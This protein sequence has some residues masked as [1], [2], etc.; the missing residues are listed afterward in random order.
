MRLLQLGVNDRLTFT[1]YLFPHEIS[2]YE[3]A[4]LSHTWGPD[5]EE[6]T[7][8]DVTE[9]TGLKKKGYQKILFCGRQAAADNLGYFWVDTCCIDKPNLTEYAEAINSMFQWYRDAS[10]CYVFL[11]DV[12]RDDRVQVHEPPRSTWKLAFRNSR[13]FTRGWTLQELIAPSSVE[14]FSSDSQRLGDKKSLEQE[15]HD[16]TNIPIHV[17]RGA[18]LSACS[19]EERI[20]WS[21]NRRTTRPEDKAYSLLGILGIHMLPICGEGEDE[22]FDRLRG[23]I[24]ARMSSRTIL[25]T[26]L[27][28]AE[29]ASFDSHAEEHNPACL[30][31]T[32]VDLLREITEWAENHDSKAV[33]WLNGM[34]GTGKSTISRTLANIFAKRGSLGASFFFKRG[35]GDRGSI[36][37]FFSTIA[38]QLIVQVPK[39]AIHIQNT[40]DAD[41]N[42]VRKA[43]RE[44]F[45]KF[46]LDPLSRISGDDYQNCLYVI[47]VDALDECES[48]EDV[49]LLIKL[50]SHSKTLRSPRLRI[51]LTSRPE[52][53]IRLGFEA[54]DGEYQDLVLH[55][56]A[57]PVIEHD[58]AVYF[59]HKLAEIKLRYNNSV[60]EER[61]LP[62]SWPGQAN[63]DILVKMA[64]PLFIFAATTCRFIAERKMGNPDTQLKEVLQYRT[65]SQEAQLDATYLPVL[66][67]MV[68]GLPRQ[69]KAEVL[70]RFHQIIG[71][72][73]TLA[74]PL[75]ISALA[76]I[77][78]LSENK[79]SDHLDLLHSVLDV[80]FSPIEPVR[81][82]HLSF[83]DFLLD[84]EKFDSPFWINEKETHQQVVAYCLRIMSETLRVDICNVGHPGTPVSSIALEEINDNLPLEV[85]Y[86]CRFWPYHLEQAGWR[87][88]DEDQVWNFLTTHFL[89]WLEALSWI[90]RTSEALKAI[91][92]LQSLTLPDSSIQ[93]SSFLDDGLRFIRAFKSVIEDAPLQIYSSALIFA[94]KQSIIRTLFESNIP[95]WILLRPKVP[96]K[97]GSN[98]QTLEGHSHFVHSVTFSPDSKFIASAS[99]DE[100]V[101]IWAADTGDLLQTLEGHGGWVRSV[102][103]SPDSKSVASGSRYYVRLWAIDTGM[104]LQTLEIHVLVMS[105]TF[106]S[107]CRCVASALEDGT[108]QLWTITGHLLQTL[109]GHTDSVTSVT[110]SPNIKLIASASRDKTIRLWASNTGNLLHTL[111]GFRGEV[112][113]VAFSP[114]GK[115]LVSGSDKICLWTVE[116]GKLLQT[117][118]SQNHSVVVGSV[119]FSSDGRLIASGSLKEV[120][121]WATN[122]GDLLQTFEGHS[123]AVNSVAFSPNDKLLVSGSSDETVRMWAIDIGNALQTPDGHSDF[124]RSVII[125]P[126]RN[127]IASGSDDNTVR[128]WDANTGNLLQTFKGHT[129]IITSLA[130]SPNHE[131]I[132]SGS[133]DKTVRLWAVTTGDLLQT[134]ISQEDIIESVA[135]SPNNKLLASGS[136]NCLVRLWATETGDLLQTLKGHNDSVTAVAFSP[137][138]RVVASASFD[139]T[140]RL[141]APDTGALLQTISTRFLTTTLRF[142]A[143]SKHLLTDVGGIPI[144]TTSS[145]RTISRF[146]S[147]SSM[148]SCNGVVG[149]GISTNE[150][151]IT[152]DGE[153]LLWLPVDCRR[154]VSAIAGSVVVIG[155][156]SGR[157]LVLNLDY[158]RSLDYIDEIETTNSTATTDSSADEVLEE[159][160]I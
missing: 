93:S 85:Q 1:K 39:A 118:E 60:R 94:P 151:W 53:P 75:P 55:E 116:T 105:V 4:I 21:H 29:G 122:T 25:L 92:T 73:V 160:N 111:Q 136:S 35:E 104:L 18:S 42:I 134:F 95:D 88:S 97:W 78:N 41:P 110:F 107:D 56:I 125:S 38:S 126:N 69:K 113:S 144:D 148:S 82:L 114:D 158:R 8:R 58:I 12:L 65:K 81:L 119:T 87:I 33:Y 28:V 30:P 50:L 49:K 157:L 46:I 155:C 150:S 20:S 98:L 68:A 133:F 9:G 64:V 156:R 6:V 132:A 48:E 34:A 43:M 19:V 3:Y 135:L 96:N 159:S 123:A 62:L 76:K 154:S 66:Y 112:K 145:M 24:A 124:I 22:A 45:E 89:H 72:V 5:E 139:N 27:P 84:P 117:F 140:I 101:R 54:V 86:T 108:I 23:I 40:V 152:I 44:Q 91:K 130:F 153:T 128:L 32:R 147:D 137:D 61:R 141:W 142:D 121:L 2:Q 57:E 51:F 90:G 31:N 74:N 103:F 146:D 16:I 149:Y 115:V 15:I 7:F 120:H 131:L 129:G 26:K 71:L 37:K 109:E 67:N 14:F 17:L 106:S 10:R 127:L 79:I 80:P 59:K 70:D 47:I 63:I 83:R 13:W 100:T 143:E 52:L 36:T 138:G 11:E 99:R 102:A 77:L